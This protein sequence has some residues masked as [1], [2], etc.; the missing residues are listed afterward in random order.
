MP[1]YVYSC[2]RCSTEVE[3]QR[4]ISEMDEP[5]TCTTC[6]EQAE[7]TGGKGTPHRMERIISAPAGHFPGAS[8]WRG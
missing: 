5:V 2:P 4:K 3:L 1:L 8:S 7:V 6:V